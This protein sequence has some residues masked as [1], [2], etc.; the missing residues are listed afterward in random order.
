MPFQ[1][2]SF[3][4]M[5]VLLQQRWD[6][7]PFWTS[8]EAESAIIEALRMWNLLTGMW[9]TR[10]VYTTIANDQWITTPGAIT[11]NMRAT[12]NEHSLEP[13]S[14]MEMDMGFPNWEGQMTSDGGNVP[15]TPKF[16]IPAGLN[17]IAI[18][19][20]DGVGNNSIIIDG[21]AITPTT[22]MFV[23][24]P[25]SEIN[26]ILGYALHVA[27]FKDAARWPFTMEFYKDFLTS[28][29]K[30]NDKL[31]ASAL[32][33]KILGLDMNNSERVDGRRVKNGH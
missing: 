3:G 10:A 8:A 21:V 25:Q 9:K 29:G 16:W 31:L 22:G 15:T 11:Y 2:I 1:N 23:D 20:G 33:R 32:Y 27:S 7:V 18:W 6:G 26:V 4:Q 5:R 12:F 13:A 24:L 14:L 17:L 28:A 19:P 30:Y